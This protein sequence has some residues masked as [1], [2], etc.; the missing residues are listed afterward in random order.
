MILLLSIT[1]R[2]IL[3]VKSAVLTVSSSISFIRLQI[4]FRHGVPEKIALTVSS[5]FSN[6][7]MT[8]ASLGANEMCQILK[9]PS[10][11]AYM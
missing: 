10:L 11:S 5:F 1:C 6:G 7:D 8:I 4:R 3:A 2:S 9:V